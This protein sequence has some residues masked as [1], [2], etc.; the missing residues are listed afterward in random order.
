MNDRIELWI[1]II[2]KKVLSNILVISKNLSL[3]NLNLLYGASDA[4]VA[5]YRA[6]G[7]NLPPLE[8]ASSG[9][10]VILTDGGS[11]DDYFNKSFA[12]KIKSKLIKKDNNIFLEPDLESLIDTMSLLVEKKFHNFNLNK[13]QNFI[14]KDF[15]WPSIVK[16]LSLIM[17]F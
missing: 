17:N 12:I 10:P 14:K 15:S 3:N 16:K 1:R 2:D 6:E 7:F 11:T 9:L 4:Y 5:P 13:T 8:A